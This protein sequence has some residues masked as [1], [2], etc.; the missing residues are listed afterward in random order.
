MI[1]IREGGFEPK[2][3]CWKPQEVSAELQGSSQHREHF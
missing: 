3:L 1:T 2:R